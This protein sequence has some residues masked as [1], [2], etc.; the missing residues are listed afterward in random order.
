MGIPDAPL[1]IEEKN[2]KV[3]PCCYICEQVPEQGIKDIFR[4]GTKFI[5]RSCEREIIMCDTNSP[6]YQDL[7]RKIKELW[8]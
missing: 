1:V 3:L 6:G 5:C 7:I 2:G 8:K 4:L